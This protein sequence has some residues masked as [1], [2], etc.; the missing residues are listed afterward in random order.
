MMDLKRMGKADAKLLLRWRAKMRSLY[1]LDAKDQDADADGGSG[2]QVEMEHVPMTVEDELDAM[3]QR[4]DKRERRKGRKEREA[5]KRALDRANRGIVRAGD[6]I[7]MG[8]D[9]ELFDLEDIW[10][11]AE[12]GGALSD[13]ED[14]EG[15]HQPQDEETFHELMERYLEEGHRNSKKRRIKARGASPPAFF[16]SGFLTG[17]RPRRSR[18]AT[19][20]RWLRR[21]PSPPR[22]KWFQTLGSS[23]TSLTTSWTWKTR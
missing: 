19:E 7:E 10:R 9:E 20:W 15:A 16:Y 21:A 23:R 5:R 4:L 1:Q 18:G 11:G 3:I 22:P 6:F 2:G 8:R 12:G 14:E 17:S 13:D